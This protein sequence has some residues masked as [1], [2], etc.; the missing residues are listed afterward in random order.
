MCL[1]LGGHELRPSSGLSLAFL[2]IATEERP[3]T[4]TADRPV[5]PSIRVSNAVAHFAASLPFRVRCSD[6]LSIGLT[7][8][9]RNVAMRRREIAP[10]PPGWRTA[11]RF[12]VDCVCDRRPHAKTGYCPRAASYWRDVDLAEPSFVVVN[13]A[14]GHAHV[15]NPSQLGL[16]CVAGGAEPAHRAFT[17]PDFF[18]RGGLRPPAQGVRMR[19]CRFSVPLLLRPHI[20]RLA[21]RQDRWELRAH[22]GAHRHGVPRTVVT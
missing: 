17:L 13:P 14:N 2:R 8:A 6:D 12:D 1:V 4:A 9:D 18:A 20:R 19:L 7:W 21:R 22:A 16:I 10:D 11:L 3:T 5:P 15:R